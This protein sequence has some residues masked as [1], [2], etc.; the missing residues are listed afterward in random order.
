ME[1]RVRYLL[2]S[3]VKGGCRLKE[4]TVEVTHDTSKDHAF[5]ASYAH[6]YWLEKAHEIGE[7]E[8]ARRNLAYTSTD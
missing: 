7:A 8:A 2:D 3:T 1:I 4:T 5:F 6:Q